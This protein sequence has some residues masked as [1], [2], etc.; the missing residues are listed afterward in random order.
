MATSIG[1]TGARAAADLARGQILAAVDLAAPP[2]RVFAALASRGI[3]DW[4][5]R[6]GVFDTREWS[7]DVRA[8]GAWR[9]SGIG[10][11]RPYTLAGKIVEVDAPRTLVHTWRCAGEPATT[12]VSYRLDPTETG[13][14]L[15]LRHE[16]F[17][18]ARTCAATAAGWETSFERLGELLGGG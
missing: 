12:T 16:G 8:G 3:T 2:E 15:T 17:T 7:G 18:D 4:W 6:P 10:G 5:V 14:R 9:A 11:G 13:T 1:P